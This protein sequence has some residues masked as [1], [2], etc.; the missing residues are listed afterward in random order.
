MKIFFAGAESDFFSIILKKAGAKSVLQSAYYLN[1]KNK[2]NKLSFNNTVIDSGGY[3]LRKNKIVMRPK[4]YIEFLNKHNV[5][6]A[7]NLDVECPFISEENFETIRRNVCTTLIP[8]YHYTD[9][10]RSNSRELFFKHVEEN[11]YVSVAG[12]GCPET[13]ER[14]EFYKWCFKHSQGKKVHGLGVTTLSDVFE[15]PFYSVDST[16]W[17]AGHRYG[18]SQ[19]LDK[20]KLKSVWRIKSNRAKTNPEVIEPDSFLTLRE[21]LKKSILDTVKLQDMATDLWSNRGIKWNG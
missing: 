1:Y 6:E 2:P 11:D 13:T 4:K 10:I 20:T 17:K 16:S 12:L 3:T 5:G 14:K 8:V 7:F 18:V 19:F 15:F 9:W 21:T